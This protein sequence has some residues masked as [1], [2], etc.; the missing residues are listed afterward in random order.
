ML[1]TGTFTKTTLIFWESPF[2]IIWHLVLQASFVNRNT[3]RS[4]IFF[5]EF[6]FFFLCT[7]AISAS[8]NSTWN[9]EEWIEVLI[10]SDIL[11][12]KKPI[13]SLNVCIHITF[14]RCFFVIKTLDTLFDHI[15]LSF[16][17][18]KSLDLFLALIRLILG[19]FSSL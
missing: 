17:E 15:N 7:D 5:R 1:C 11:F 13:F 12:A 18:P 4:I 10:S 9:F 16:L 2:K 19:C 3:N 14:L 6:W 8:F